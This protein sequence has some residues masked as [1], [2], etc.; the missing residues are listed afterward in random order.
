MASLVYIQK[1]NSDIVDYIKFAD[2]KAAA[3]LTLAGVVGGGVGSTT[4]SMLETSAKLKGCTGTVLGFVS[5]CVILAALVVAICCIGALKARTPKA[6]SINSFP[7]I[8]SMPKSDDYIA[9]L[10]AQDEPSLSTE[11]ARHNWSLSSIAMSKF[12]CIN[13]AVVSLGVQMLLA[14]VYGVLSVVI[15]VSASR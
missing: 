11:L 3:L 6:N 8:A 1:V 5:A 4:T 12:R 10:E 7:D 13:C 14:T 2:T 9:S 15:A